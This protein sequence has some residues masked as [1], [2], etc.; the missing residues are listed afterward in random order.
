[1]LRAEW[2]KHYHSHVHA[3]NMKL[4]PA[5]QKTWQAWDLKQRWTASHMRRIYKSTK[6]SKSTA[7]NK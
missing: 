4:E 7:K 6:L 2:A 1:M 5:G 3:L